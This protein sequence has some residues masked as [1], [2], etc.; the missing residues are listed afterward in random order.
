MAYKSS[1]GCEGRM[2]W[3]TVPTEQ[4]PSHPPALP[5]SD[6]SRSGLGLRSFRTECRNEGTMKRSQRKLLCLK[7]ALFLGIFWVVG[8]IELCFY[9]P[10]DSNPMV[11]GISM[12][13]S[14]QACCFCIVS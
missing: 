7:N 12:V 6:I 4:R 8:G 3:T 2:E 9:K 1:L 10:S 5:S 13:S 14:E 11:S